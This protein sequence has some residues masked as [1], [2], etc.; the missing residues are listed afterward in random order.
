MGWDWFDLCA[1]LLFNT[2]QVKPVFVG[3]K[4]HRQPQMTKPPRTTNSVKIR[5]RILWEVKIDDNVY[6]LNVNSS[7]EQI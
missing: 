3:D 5:L 7:C 1:K 6:G 2:I 4:V